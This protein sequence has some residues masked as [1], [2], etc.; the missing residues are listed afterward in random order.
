MNNGE[1]KTPA[2]HFHLE[3]LSLVSCG[4]IN[5]VNREECASLS[6]YLSVQLPLSERQARMEFDGN[7]HNDHQLIRI[8]NG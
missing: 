8:R 2:Q 1:R 7:G 5:Y 6:I 3:R 4:R